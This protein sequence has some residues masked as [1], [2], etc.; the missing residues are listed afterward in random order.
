MYVGLLC[1]VDKVV[2]YTYQGLNITTAMLVTTRKHWTE[3]QYIVLPFRSFV[4]IPD[5]DHRLHDI[6]RETEPG[7]KPGNI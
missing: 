7:T 1:G 4:F 5:K 2:L 6:A 3:G